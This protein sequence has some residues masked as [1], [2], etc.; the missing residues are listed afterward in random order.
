MSKLTLDQLEAHLWESANILRGSIDPGDYKHYILGLLF[1]K[2]LSDVWQEEYEARLAEFGDKEL[3]A[4]PDEHRFHI[5]EDHFWADVRKSA[6]NI[7]ERLN[8]AFHG[9]ED[10]NLRLKGIFCNGPHHSYR[11]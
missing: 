7:G 1:Y 9:I 6:I 10:A 2:R 4:D 5:P 11:T 3:A 8:Q